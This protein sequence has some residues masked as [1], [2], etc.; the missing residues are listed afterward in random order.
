MIRPMNIKQRERFL[1][2][3]YEKPTKNLLQLESSARKGN[4]IDLQSYCTEWDCYCKDNT[5]ALIHTMDIINEFKE[6]NNSDIEFIINRDILP[7][8]RDTRGASY[9]I[10]DFINKNSFSE[11][12]SLKF[13]D[14]VTYDRVL[15][16]Q[17][18]IDENLNFD[19]YDD[20][21]DM[22]IAISTLLEDSSLSDEEKYIV[23]VENSIYSAFKCKFF[24]EEDYKEAKDSVDLFFS[25]KDNRSFNYDEINPMSDAI[26]E[27][28]KVKEE[29]L[30]SIV[31][32]VMYGKTNIP[33]NENVDTEKRKAK[34]LKNKVTKIFA[35]KPESIIDELPD[36]F[37]VIRVGCMLLALG[38]NPYLGLVTFITERIIK[39]KVE[40]DQADK[41]L[42]QYKKELDKAR[43]K[44]DKSK[45]EKNKESLKKYIQELEDNYDKLERYYDKWNYNKNDDDDST[46]DETTNLNELRNQLFSR[47]F[48]NGTIDDVK[49]NIKP[50][51]NS[52]KESV[53]CTKLEN[54]EYFL[55]LI[56]VSS[57]VVSDK[58]CNESLRKE[59]DYDNIMES[60][61]DIIQESLN[62]FRR[63]KDLVRKEKLRQFTYECMK[64]YEKI[65]NT[66]H[67]NT[68]LGVKREKV[69]NLWRDDIRLV[70][71]FDDVYYVNEEEQVVLNELEMSNR[72]KL[73]QQRLKKEMQKVSDKD[74]MISNQ[75]DHAYDRFVY[76]IEKQMSNKNREAVIKGSLIPSLS[77]LIK[78]GTTSSLIAFF[79]NPLC[80]AITAFC[81][82]AA[83]KHATEKERKYILEEIDIQLDII[84]K[85]LQLAESNND[86]KAYEQLLRVQRQLQSERNRII[87]K[88]RRSVVAT[89]YN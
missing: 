28:K 67:E 49:Y 42:A 54:S 18:I 71:D 83:S 13:N 87:Y 6:N 2:S 79:V 73:A 58:I 37:T 10:K 70:D 78:L 47:K 41:I 36:L 22:S 11:A 80:A 82:L 17:K 27:T 3:Q 76:Q 57:I 4:I 21:D 24:H 64:N 89:K 39:T 51:L 30:D 53:L 72:L 33:V 59:K 75:L 48:N 65:Y 66:C 34:G 40:T 26:K 14:I 23:S 69:G 77:S 52:I 20:I 46:F 32:T 63:E 88:K 38:V 29:S 1:K 61:E 85:K 60:Y 16:N 5:K 19:A 35:R 31:E 12:V 84:G 45:S 62:D 15:K 68:E 74:K 9:Y 86:M 81:G 8:V 55:G 56:D 43:K 25:M 50:I 44:L 7:R